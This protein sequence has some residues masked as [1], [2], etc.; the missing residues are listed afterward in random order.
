MSNKITLLAYLMIIFEPYD[1]VVLLVVQFELME[2]LWL[3][4]LLLVE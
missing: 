4:A 1:L 3:V 2:D